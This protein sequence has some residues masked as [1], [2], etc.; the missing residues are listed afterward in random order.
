[1]HAFVFVAGLLLD[2]VGAL[3]PHNL[4]YQYMHSSR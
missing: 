1:M 4:R 2:V 3:S